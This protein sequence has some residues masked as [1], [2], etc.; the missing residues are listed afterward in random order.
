MLIAF[1]T[2]EKSDNGII[3]RT[4]LPHTCHNSCY[5]PKNSHDLDVFKTK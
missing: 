5:I 1:A 2:S 3:Y 4:N